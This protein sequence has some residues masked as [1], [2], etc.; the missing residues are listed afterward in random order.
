MKAIKRRDADA[1]FGA[2]LRCARSCRPAM[3]QSLHGPHS[4]PWGEPSEMGHRW[5]WGSVGLP[6]GAA[7]CCLLFSGEETLS[8]HTRPWL[9]SAVVC[10]HAACVPEPQCF[11]C[12]GGS[13]TNPGD[14][15]R[16]ANPLWQHRISEVL[17]SNPSFLS[18]AF[19]AWHCDAGPLQ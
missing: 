10:T 18:A 7:L 13:C 16:N 2:E 9:S 3:G 4:S 1:A 19:P 17:H 11:P 14:P 12:T 8:I 5:D 15:L 6:R